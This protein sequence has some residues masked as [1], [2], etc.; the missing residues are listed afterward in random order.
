MPVSE[1][2]HKAYARGDADTRCYRDYVDRQH[3]RNK[4]IKAVLHET[5]MKAACKVQRQ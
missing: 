3:L 4:R 1:G 2:W 5:L